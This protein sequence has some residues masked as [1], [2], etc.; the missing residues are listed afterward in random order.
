[1][2]AVSL[3][4]SR[5]TNY[6]CNLGSISLAWALSDMFTFLF[7]IQKLLCSPSEYKVSL[8]VSPKLEQSVTTETALVPGSSGAEEVGALG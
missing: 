4:L 5:A 6:V 7:N 1:M 3:S 8:I 2:Q